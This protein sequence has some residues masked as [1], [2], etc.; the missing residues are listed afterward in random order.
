MDRVEL[1]TLLMTN[2]KNK[3]KVKLS[4][5][6]SIFIHEN[7]EL[8]KVDE[9]LIKDFCDL[10]YSML[11]L[12]GTYEC[13]LC[14]D[15]KSEKIKTT[16]ICFFDKGSVKI[17]CQSRS[18]A[19]ILR[20]IGHEMFHLRQYEMDLIPVKKKLHHLDPVEWHA[21]IAGGS[22]LSYFADITGKDKIYR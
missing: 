2:L 7:L 10:C 1:V 17:Y 6:F 13:F 15:R 12:T 4:G 8:E 20:S 16:A 19:D 5:D 11:E 22:L 9:K 3:R 14:N 21:N 18:L